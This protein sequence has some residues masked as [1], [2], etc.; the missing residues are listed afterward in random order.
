MARKRDESAQEKQARKL[1][2][3]KERHTARVQKKII[4]QVFKEESRKL[5]VA[6]GTNELVG[7]STFRY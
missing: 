4:K 1:A 3:K 5:N 7:Q 6:S 2:A